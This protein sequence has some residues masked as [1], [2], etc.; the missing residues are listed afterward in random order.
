MDLVLIARQPADYVRSR[1]WTHTLGTV[2]HEQVEAYGRLTSVRVR[3]DNGLEVEFGWTDE[4]WVARPLDEGTRLVLAGGVR[5]LFERR[6]VLSSA[7][8]GISGKV[9]SPRA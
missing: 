9:A 1:S 3:Y 5:V 6:T 2:I 8:K 7:L 4:S